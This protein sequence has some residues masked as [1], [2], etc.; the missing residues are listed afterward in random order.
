MGADASG[1]TTDIAQDALDG[2]HLEHPPDRDGNVALE[3]EM[4][5]SRHELQH[6]RDARP[7]NVAVHV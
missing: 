4:D 6:V 2:T 3:A 5:L 7:R 1:N